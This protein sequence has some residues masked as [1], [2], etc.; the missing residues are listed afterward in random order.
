MRV[1]DVRLTL[2][3]AP[4]RVRLLGMPAE[5]SAALRQAGLVVVDEESPTPETGS[6]APDLVI[7]QPGQAGHAVTAGARQIVIAGRSSDRLLR[8]AGYQVV[9][10]LVRPGRTGPRLIAPFAHRRAL[11]YA[12]ADSS[13]PD[14]RRLRRWLAGAAFRGPF[15]RLLP[16]GAVVTLGSRDPG[17]P[18]PFPPDLTQRL[19]PGAEWV[20]KL[21]TGDDL[22]RAVFLVFP[23]AAPVPAWV[24]KLGR[25]SGH[26]TGFDRDAEGLARAAGAGRRTAAHTPVLLTRAE[27]NGQPVIV[28]SAGVGQ[29]LHGLLAG[30]LRA[31]VKRGLV[32]A[33][34]GWTL[35]V[36]SETRTDPVGLTEELARL[37]GLA[38][39]P[40]A[41]AAELVDHLPPLSGVLAHN[42]LGTWNIIARPPDRFT[43]VD[44]ESS[45]PVGLPLWDLVYFLADA[46]PRL[47]DPQG[48]VSA[49]A[50]VALFRGEHS[51]SRTLFGWLRR[52][53]EALAIPDAA[54]GP[55]TTLCVL[56]HAASV[57]ARRRELETRVGPDAK[58]DPTRE[59]SLW[60]EVAQ[61]WCRDT[62]LGPA[63]T[64]WR[65]D[66]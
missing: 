66:P 48:R 3:Q 42:D 13:R 61:A 18:Y 28:E 14:G 21:G 16:P 60:P 62:S 65:R 57:S 8:A 30:S 7:A 45:R 53:V 56:H 11:R 4:V 20:L 44:W 12:A 63:W 5:W 33:V 24:V 2:P 59:V 17:L 49:D 10:L 37:R 54:V 34:A 31:D 26:A 36:A 51:E 1:A 29:P 55:V 64:G 47:A 50:V 22:Q 39:P 15:H 19:G 32:A 58:A 27:V 40:L 9:R 52:A 41:S 6:E 35:D 25:V 38:A 46:L 23:P 43:V